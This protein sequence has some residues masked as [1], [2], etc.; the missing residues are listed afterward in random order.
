MNLKTIKRVVVATDFSELSTEAVDTAIGFAEA[1][2][3]MLDLV[4][5]APELSIALPPPMDAIS[6][7]F[8]AA[9]AM[10]EASKR[11][12][13]EQERLRGRG[14]PCESS[15][16][17]GRADT[18]IVAHAEKTHADL[19]IIGTHGRGGLAHALFGSVAEKVVQHAHCPVLSVPQRHASQ[20]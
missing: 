20:G 10:N 9:A 13:A 12:S 5:V 11:T 4:Y 7:P 1:F 16:L 2:G 6:L 19:I 18:E 3:A 15:V 17:V 8:D 14:I